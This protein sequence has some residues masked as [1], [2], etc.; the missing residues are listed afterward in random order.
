MKFW[1]LERNTKISNTPASIFDV[2]PAE[3]V[4]G[5]TRNW[6]PE[7][8]VVFKTGWIPAPIDVG[9]KLSDGNDIVNN[10]LI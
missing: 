2:T 3:P 9:V 5:T 6:L 10:H 8:L 7:V 1:R 4:P